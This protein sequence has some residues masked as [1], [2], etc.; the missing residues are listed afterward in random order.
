MYGICLYVMFHLFIDI[1]HIWYSRISR[2]HTIDFTLVKKKKD[3]MIYL[4]KVKFIS[5]SI[6]QLIKR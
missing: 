6:N 1:F 5:Q 3:C 2:I 4:N